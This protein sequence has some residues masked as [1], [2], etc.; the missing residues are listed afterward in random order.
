MSQNKKPRE[1]IGI[2]PGGDSNAL[3]SV[4]IPEDFYALRSSN[5]PDKIELIEKSAYEA[6]Q[7]EIES[8]TEINYSLLGDNQNL[9]SELKRKNHKEDWER[10]QLALALDKRNEMEIELTA[11]KAEVESY[12]SVLSK[13]INA[14]GYVTDADIVGGDIYVLPGVFIPHSALNEVDKE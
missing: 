10:L 2:N 14:E 9:K 6:L 8:L 1:Y 7:I 11:A 12:K 13:G 3:L 4:L 5:H